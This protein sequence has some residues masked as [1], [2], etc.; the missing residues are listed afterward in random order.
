MI[1]ANNSRSNVNIED[2]K[3]LLIIDFLEGHVPDGWLERNKHKINFDQF[4]SIVVANYELMLDGS[5]TIQCNL[6]V[7]YAQRSFVPK[8][9][10]PMLKF[11]QGFKTHPWLQSHLNDRS[12]L[13]LTPESMQHHVESMVPQVTD[14]LVVGGGWQMCTH[15]R[16]L[17]FYSLKNM[18]YNF[19]ITEWS[20]I[21]KKVAQPPSSL[22]HIKNDNLIWVDHTNNLFQL[23]RDDHS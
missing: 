20:M 11:A 7:E 2:L 19:Y 9:L 4:H 13:I 15:T 10:L 12:Y 16:P 23:Q 6:L 14:W 18:P 22:E 21:G 3:G 8:M 17:G 1:V 5:D